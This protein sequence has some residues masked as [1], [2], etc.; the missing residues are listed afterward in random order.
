M[1]ATRR[2][3]IGA[4]GA[5]CLLP[6]AALAAASIVA[7]SGD[8]LSVRTRD[9]LTLSVMAYGNP[10]SPEIV[11]V[12]G[13]GQSRLAWDQQVTPEMAGRFRLVTYDLR[14]H[15]DSDKPTCPPPTRR[16]PFWATTCTR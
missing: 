15:G 9:G 7:P 11:F 5:A 3:F 10:R 16:A 2:Q 8:T 4:G 13:L 14:G 1:Q 6:A 12:H